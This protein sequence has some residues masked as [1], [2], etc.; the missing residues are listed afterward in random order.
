MTVGGSPFHNLAVAGKNECFIVTD[1]MKGMK[2]LSSDP[3]VVDVSD[4]K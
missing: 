1:M 2:Y 4:L 3:R